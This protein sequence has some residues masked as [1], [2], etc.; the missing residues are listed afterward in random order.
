M[1]QDS[2]EGSGL[3]VLVETCEIM[4]TTMVEKGE[5]AGS[6]P[7]G[8]CTKQS[9]K[10][11][12]AGGR[13]DA[14]IPR[15]RANEKGVVLSIDLLSN[16]FGESLDVV[17]QK[18]GISKTTIK[19]VQATT[20]SHCILLPTNSWPNRF[21][22]RH[23]DVLGS[24]S[25]L[26]STEGLANV[27][28][29]LQSCKRVRN[30][31]SLI[32]FSRKSFTRFFPRRVLR[33]T[34][35]KCANASLTG[36]KTRRQALRHSK[37]FSRRYNAC[38]LHHHSHVRRGALTRYPPCPPMASRVTLVAACLVSMPAILPRDCMVFWSLLW[39]VS[40]SLG[41]ALRGGQGA[42]ESVPAVPPADAPGSDKKKPPV[43]L[44]A[45]VPQFIR[46]EDWSFLHEVGLT[47]ISDP[48]TA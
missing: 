10:V 30:Y 23:A 26:T 34:R 17:T 12:A 1:R 36:I 45:P 44:L 18:L 42:K 21:S 15:R 19:A 3:A 7:H 24:P 5:E 38:D 33:R 46:E 13:V 25:G 27:A 35:V 8:P 39:N 37:P 32:A 9:A 20:S 41:Q 14:V 40:F 16:Y 31:A 2:G 6:A 28:S 22:R 4:A 48:A 47:G 43:V 29:S 11:E